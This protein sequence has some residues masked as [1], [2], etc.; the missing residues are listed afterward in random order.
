MI[1]WITALCNLMKLWAMLCRAT[2]DRW[3]MVERDPAFSWISVSWPRAIGA[4][5]GKP[6]WMPSPAGCAW[7]CQ[8]SKSGLPRARRPSWC[9]RLWMVRWGPVVC[10]PFFRSYRQSLLWIDGTV[11]LAN[12]ALESFTGWIWILVWP[13]TCCASLG[14][15]LKLGCILV[16]SSIKW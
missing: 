4:S 10:H 2:Q 13:P 16:S 5:L 11:G 7:Y 15:L 12:I 6:A 1:T 9:C 8:W 3:I 14:H